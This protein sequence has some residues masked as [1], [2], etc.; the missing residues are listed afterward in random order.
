MTLCFI[1][2]AEAVRVIAECVGRE[3]RR[4]LLAEV[5]QAWVDDIH[6]E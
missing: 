6:E 4:A 1:E 3:A 5:I 2:P